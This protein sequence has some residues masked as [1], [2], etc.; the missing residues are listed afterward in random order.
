L[1]TIADAL[2]VK[3][4]FKVDGISQFSGTRKRTDKYFYNE[5]NERITFAGAPAFAYVRRGVTDTLVRA[6]HGQRGLYEIGPRR[7]WIGKRVSG[8]AALG[9]DIYGVPS[10]M[11]ARP[12][13]EI[14]LERVD[15]SSGSVPALISGT[16]TRSSGRGPVLIVVNGTVAAVSEIWPEQGEPSFGGMVNAALFKH[17]KNELQLYELDGAQLRPIELR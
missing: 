15:P 8:L 1:P 7:D 13:P 12:A 3:V 4:P 14:D 6:A 10:Q 2:D 16:L 17:G 11:T 9:V 5:P